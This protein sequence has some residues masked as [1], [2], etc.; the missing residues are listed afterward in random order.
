LEYSLPKPDAPFADK[1][2]H[3]FSHQ[4]IPSQNYP[5]KFRMLRYQQTTSDSPNQRHFI[6][7]SWLWFIT[8]IGTG[9]YHFGNSLALSIQK[10]LGLVVIYLPSLVR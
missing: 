5:D 2:V 3:L 1:A 8:A 6:L 10:G 4:P 7:F 9:F